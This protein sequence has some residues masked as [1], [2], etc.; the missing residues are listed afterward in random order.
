MYLKK[1]SYALNKLY[2]LLDLNLFLK[3]IILLSNT[4]LFTNYYKI[5]NKKY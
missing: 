3:I 1:M 4:K 2:L 5:N